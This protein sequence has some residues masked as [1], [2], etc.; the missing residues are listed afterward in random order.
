[1][2]PVLAFHTPACL[3]LIACSAGSLS[4][5][6]FWIHLGP[7]HTNPFSNENGAVLLRIWLSSTLQHR[8]RSPKTESFENAL[9]SGGIW[10]QCF[11][12]RLFSSV[13]GE[14][15]ATWKR[16]RHPN[17]HDRAPAHSTVRIQNGGQT[18]PCGFSLDR[19]DFHSSDALA[20]AFNQQQQRIENGANFPGRY[21]EMRIRRVHLSMRT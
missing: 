2:K 8:K 12:K 16:W 11:L 6:P 14:N 13:D 18:V 7:V 5:N 4:L 9:Q 21:I 20:S 15:D 1:M 3:S 19:N 10:K 17:R